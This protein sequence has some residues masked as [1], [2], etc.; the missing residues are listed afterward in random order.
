[1]VLCLTATALADVRLPDNLRPKANT[2]SSRTN[3]GN[4]SRMT[5]E[6]RD[7]AEASRLQIPRT[8]LRQLRA[9]LEG[10]DAMVAGSFGSGAS[11]L[12][13][14]VAGVFLSL[15][16]IFGGVWLL[17][18]KRGATVR[19][20]ATLGVFVCALCASAATAVVLANIAPPR[21]TVYWPDTLSRAVQDGARLEGPVRVEIVDGGTDIKL[22]VPKASAEE[23]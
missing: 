11:P 21:R 19:R 9:E 16:V 23:R 12:Q 1:M 6:A 13:T 4:V 8:V 5:I 20:V 2:N 15:T 10:E 17:R 22:I 14:I 7:G 3:N 18:M